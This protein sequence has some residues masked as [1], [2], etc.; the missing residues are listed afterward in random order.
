MRYW[1]VHSS[2][3]CETRLLLPSLRYHIPGEQWI[4]DEPMNKEYE[5]DR[6]FL[7]VI[8][9]KCMI[10]Y[11]IFVNSTQHE[12]LENLELA[13]FWASMHYV[14]EKKC[15]Y[16]DKGGCFCRPIHHWFIHCGNSC[17]STMS[18]MSWFSIDRN[19]QNDLTVLTVNFC[20]SFSMLSREMTN[21]CMTPFFLRSD[22]LAV[23][24]KGNSYDFMKCEM[25]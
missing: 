17:L 24:G 21:K 1:Y 8:H 4:L 6:C 12:K 16:L 14:G 3:G 20:F 9:C 13:Q 10:L 7:L 11:D 22:M 18:H 5:M 25:R 23:K 2:W 15:W 19:H